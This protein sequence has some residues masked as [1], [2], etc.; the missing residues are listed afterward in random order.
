M[1]VCVPDILTKEE[2]AQ[3]KASLKIL[4]FVN[5]QE[6]AGRRAKRVKNN[7]QVSQDAPERK[8]IQR[9]VASALMRSAAFRI[10][11]LPKKI[12]PPLI[13]QY[14][15]G[16]A[17]GLHIDDAMMGPLESRT[18]SDV[19]VTVFLNDPSE[20]TG[21]ELLIHH[22]SGFQPVKLP[23]GCAVIYPSNTLHEVA[24]VTD[25]ERWVCATWVESYVRD[26]NKRE[27]LSDLLQ[28]REK[29][30]DIAPDVK[31]TDLAYRA[32]ANL[33]RLWAE[34]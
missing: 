2:L 16:M 18:R 22:A 25:G 8:E 34:T 33:M 30:H 17:Y 26:E 13:S 11:A 6:T 24:Q 10:A 19:S 28:I 4:P 1:L 31:E 23:A 12:R 27:I 15:K 21:G 9:V 32:H 20:Y 29:M 14:Q 3:I 5:G 7:L